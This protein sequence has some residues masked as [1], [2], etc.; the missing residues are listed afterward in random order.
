MALGAT[1]IPRH[2]RM[3]DAHGS[4]QPSPLLL[5]DIQLISSTVPL[6]SPESVI[7][8]QINSVCFSVSYDLLLWLSQRCQQ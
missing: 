8:S 2:P 4:F 7:F 1:F 6:P 5:E 3:P